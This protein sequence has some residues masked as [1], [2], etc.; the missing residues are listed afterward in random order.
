MRILRGRA[1]S[2]QPLALTIGN[3]DG[4]HRGH[5]ALLRLVTERA[6]ECHL[7]PAVLTFEPHPRERLAPA[8][9]PP[10][11]TPLRTKAAAIAQEGIAQLH[12]LPFTRSVAQWSSETFITYL[13]TT[14]QVRHLV[15]GDDFR[16]GAHRSGNLET[17]LDA[18]ER[19]GFTVEAMP[20]L[21]WGSERVS[22][23]A[24][25]AALAAGN[26][27]HAAELLGRWFSVTGRVTRG[28]Q[29]G[30]TLDVP[31]M[32]LR[33]PPRQAVPFGVFVGW[34]SGVSAQPEPAVI[35]VGVRPT[36]AASHPPT[37]EAHLLAWRGDAY[38]ARITVHFAAKLR[39]E[40][41]FASLA[42]LKAQLDDDIAAAR[43]WHTA[44]DFELF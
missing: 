11:L 12:I 31:T 24:V 41:R 3:F 32:N 40:Q 35:N 14:L 44:H 36:V 27:R 39:E 29:M 28:A 7:T 43:R 30:R 18:G 9:A 25:R 38:G 5:Q 21:T 42:A 1:P 15:V 33:L 8:S 23:S 22:S 4:V 17:L 34:V 37:V 20:T 16:F 2:A 26:L 13:V 10:R 19:F 6:E